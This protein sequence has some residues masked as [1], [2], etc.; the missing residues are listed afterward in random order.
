M[1]VISITPYAKKRMEKLARRH[2]GVGLLMD[3]KLSL[4]LHDPTARSLRLH[5]LKNRQG[6]WSISLGY[7][8]R[9]IFVYERGG[10]TVFDIGSHDEVY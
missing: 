7:D 5:K 4:Y 2:P 1:T 10:L 9:L 6:A 8:L 3:D